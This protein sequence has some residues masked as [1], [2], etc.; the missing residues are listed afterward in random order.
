MQVAQKS[1]SSLQENNKRDCSTDQLFVQRGSSLACE[2]V[3]C[4]GEA[5]FAESVELLA[6]MSRVLTQERLSV[7]LLAGH[8]VFPVLHQVDVQVDR[9]VIPQVLEHAIVHFQRNINIPLDLLI[10]IVLLLLYG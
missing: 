8:V 2:Q 7:R 5:Q 6:G 1:H 4:L 9:P 3:L 10:V